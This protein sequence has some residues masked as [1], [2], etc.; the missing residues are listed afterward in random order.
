[1]QS[2]VIAPSQRE[3]GVNDD[4]TP[5]SYTSSPVVAPQRHYAK[6]KRI[7]KPTTPTPQLPKSRE[8]VEEYSNIYLPH[9]KM[10]VKVPNSKIKEN[11]ML[12]KF[13]YNENPVSEYALR[14]MSIRKSIDSD[15][16]VTSKNNLS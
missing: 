13:L 10:M 15:V 1:M 11:P 5:T 14:N 2:R 12:K 9:R 4:K 7:S 8:P 3:A 6:H 16:S